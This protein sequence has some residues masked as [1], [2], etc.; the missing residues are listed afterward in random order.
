MRQTERV[1][2]DQLPYR[3]NKPSGIVA[4]E[5]AAAQGL[6]H[7][8]GHHALWTASQ[9]ISGSVRPHAQ[10]TAASEP[11]SAYTGANPSPDGGRSRG[12]RGI[13]FRRPMGALALR[14][15]SNN[16]LHF[17]RVVEKKNHQ[18]K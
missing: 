8:F 16:K 4:T 6:R 1:K 7:A 14:A 2:G 12:E 18:V 3:A 13:Q 17:A 9:K 5:V 10:H 15:R 11:P